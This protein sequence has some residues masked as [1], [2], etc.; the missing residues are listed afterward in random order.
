[1]SED[2]SLGRAIASLRLGRPVRI[3]GPGTITILP[4]ETGTPGMLRIADPQDQAPLLISGQR[5]AALSLANA[6]EAADPGRP[7]LIQRETWL[8]PA[9]ALALADPGR[10]LTR[11][12][13]GPLQPLRLDQEALT[14]GRS[15]SRAW[16][17][18]CLRC[19]SSASRATA[20]G[21]PRRN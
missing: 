17:D 2:S 9:A 4:V 21:D 12:P 7:V 20:P 15:G 18:C 8:D 5:A 3:E 6:R 19:G 16:P 14:G 13:I 10:D 1:L 11:G